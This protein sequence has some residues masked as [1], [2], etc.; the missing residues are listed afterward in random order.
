MPDPKKKKLLAILAEDL[1]KG[2]ASTRLVPAS[3]CTA[4]ITT[5]ENCVVSGV[6]EAVFLLRHSKAKVKVHKKDGQMA[7]KGEKIITATGQNK[8]VLECERTILNVL[9]RMSGVATLCKK[10]SAIAG[11]KTRVFLTRKT[12]PGFNEFDKKACMHGGVFP[13]R[14]NLAEMI[15]FKDNHLE[16]ASITGLLEKAHKAKKFTP[17]KKVEVEV[18][19]TKQAIEAAENRADII[20]LDNF[21]PK[22]AK[23]T[24]ARIKKTNP[25]ALVELS[26]GINLKNLEKYVNIGADMVSMGQ[27][28]KEAKMV[29]FSMAIKKAK[30]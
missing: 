28:T 29:D 18:D 22:R 2:D 16:F 11:K 7:K 9:G 6:E 27:L 26:G 15:L 17:A 8:P 13:H 14:K 5:G 12:M 1:L 19:N 4:A 30:S 24:I 3:K 23:K 10:A 20:M 21:S 25:A